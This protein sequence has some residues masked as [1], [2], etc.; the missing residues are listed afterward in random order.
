MFASKVAGCFGCE[1]VTVIGGREII[2]SPQITNLPEGF[3]YIMAITKL[4]I[5]PLI[6]SEIIQMESFFKDVC[7]VEDTGIHTNS[8]CRSS[9]SMPLK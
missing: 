8:V 1:N 4:Q 9:I 3:H 6:K 5:H 2:K 7:E